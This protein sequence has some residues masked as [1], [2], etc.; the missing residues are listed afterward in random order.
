MML[1]VSL[2]GRGDLGA[3]EEGVQF[4]WKTSGSGEL[5]SVAKIDIPEGFQFLGRSDTRELMRMMGNTLTQKE[6]G[7]LAPIDDDWFIVFEFDEVGYVKD[8][9]K[10]DADEVLA[11]FREGQEMDNERRRSQGFPTLEIVGWAREPFYNEDTNNLEWALQLRSSGGGSSVN[12]QTKMLGRKGVMEAVLVCDGSQLDR[13]LP[14]YQEILTGFNYEAGN[15][16]AE[17][18]KGDKIAEYG[19]T[20]L[21][22]G[23][24]AFAGAKLGLFGALLGFLKKAW[25]LVV[26]ALVGIGSWFKRLFSRGKNQYTVDQ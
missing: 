15:S 9:E 22:V 12:Y 24:A 26:A 23:G 1:A 4:D 8:D 10:P 7:T 25:Y 2:S 18:K 6:L 14:T 13:I 19:L 3:Q 21:M 11:I 16:Y 20:G 5:G 17:Y